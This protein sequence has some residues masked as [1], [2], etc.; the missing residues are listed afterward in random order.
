MAAA[1]QLATATLEYDIVGEE[2]HSYTIYN[3]QIA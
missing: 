2:F 1:K 3:L